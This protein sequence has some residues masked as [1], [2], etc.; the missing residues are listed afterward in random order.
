M[1]P[2]NTDSGLCSCGVSNDLHGYHRINCKHFAGKAWKSAHDTVQE[3]IAYELRRVSL[4]VVEQDAQLRRNFS[5]LTSNKRGDLAVNAQNTDLRLIASGQVPRADFILDIKLVAMV[6][7]QG[8]WTG[9]FN[10]QT[11]Q[12]S[13]NVL[14]QAE[15]T[16]CNK[17]E[18]HYAAIGFGF[19]PVVGSCFGGLGT[20]ALRLLMALASLELRHHDAYRARTGLDPL[21]D[22]S[23][24]SQFRMLCFRQSSARVGFALA[25]ATVK[26]LL[27]TPSLPF[28]PSF[29]RIPLGLNRPGPADFVPHAFILPCPSPLPSLPSPFPSPS[30]P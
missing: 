5:H 7:G 14:A 3:A 13:N 15:K 1:P 9:T 30:T 23:A 6:N 18:A 19:A 12:Y 24:R 27:A 21:A 20:S 11:G 28:Q 29:L 25:K 17:H 22:P 4:S 8:A 16:K 10:A 2:P 26:R